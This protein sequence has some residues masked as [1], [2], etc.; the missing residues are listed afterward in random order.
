MVDLWSGTVLSVVDHYSV[1][2]S[3]RVTGW[4]VTGRSVVCHLSVTFLLLVGQWSAKGLSL[5]FTY[6]LRV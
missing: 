4:S 3:D 6:V 5:L 2:G 1:I